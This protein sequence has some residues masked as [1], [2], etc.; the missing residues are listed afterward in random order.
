MSLAEEWLSEDNHQY[1]EDAFYMKEL[2][3]DE[4]EGYNDDSLLED[5][6]LYN[7]LEQYVL[8]CINVDKRR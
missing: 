2:S 6:I 5:D 1:E 7:K 3:F 4:G 8:Q